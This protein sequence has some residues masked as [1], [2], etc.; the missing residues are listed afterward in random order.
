MI[1]YCLYLNK[2]ELLGFA[3]KTSS[4]LLIVVV[5]QILSNLGVPLRGSPLCLRSKQLIS[6]SP[7]PTAVW[8]PRTQTGVGVMWKWRWGGGQAVFARHTLCRKQAGVVGLL[9]SCRPFLATSLTLD[10]CWELT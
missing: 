2:G 4:G 6:P 3:K 1:S 8:Q 9:C 5:S 7:P 10:Y